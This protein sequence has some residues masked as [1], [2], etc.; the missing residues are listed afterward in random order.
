MLRCIFQKKVVNIFYCSSV[1]GQTDMELIVVL[2]MKLCSSLTAALRHFNRF[3]L[4][5]LLIIGLS[6]NVRMLLL[7]KSE[8]EI[9]LAIVG[10]KK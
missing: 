6:K 9:S 3:C 10:E 7:R 8:F 5:S 1:F 2:P 4:L